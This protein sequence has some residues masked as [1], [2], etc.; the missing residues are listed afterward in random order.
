[1]LWL[2]YSGR[3]IGARA[4]VTPSGT[5]IASV[6]VR[7]ERSGTG[8]SPSKLWSVDRTKTSFNDMSL[9]YIGMVLLQLI[10]KNP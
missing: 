9:R 2:L 6:S 7:V 1:M 4:K 5:M 8:W 3:I 10:P